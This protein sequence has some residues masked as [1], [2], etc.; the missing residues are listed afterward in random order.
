MLSQND[1]L[2][3]PKSRSA[4]LQRRIGASGKPE[5]QLYY[6][7]K[8]ISFDDPAHFGFGEALARQSRFSA[9][10]AVAWCS[11]EWPVVRDLLDQ[12]LENGVLRRG[13]ANATDEILF[14]RGDL[15]SPLP[16]AQLTTP[17]CWADGPDVMRDLTGTALEPGYLEL[18][19]PIFRV[20]HMFMDQDGRQIGEANVFPKALRLDVPTEWRTCAYPG[21]RYQT[22][23]PM[24]VTALRAMRAHWQQM[25]ALLLKVRAVYIARFPDA[26]DGW[27]VGHLERL[28]TAVL[29]LPSFMMLRHDAPLRNG[30]LHPVLSNLFRVTD[31]LRMTMH[32]MLFVPIA[33][34]MLKPSDTM[35]AA[36][37]FGYAERNY[38]FHSDHGVCAGPRF[39]IEEFLSVLIDGAEP[40]NGLPEHLDS[41]VEAAA[42][43]IEPALD[44]AMLGLQSYGVVFSL[45]PAMTRAYEQI[46]RILDGMP[47]SE[48]RAADSVRDRFRSH[49]HS[50]SSSYLANEDWRR[51]RE[52]VY[53]DMYAECYRAVH[54]KE[55]VELLSAQIR[56]SRLAEHG[57]ARLVLDL[58]IANRL[59]REPNDELVGKIGAAIMDFLGSAQ[60]ILKLAEDIQ[61]HTNQL[62]ARPQPQRPVTLADINLHNLLLGKDQR[63]LP[64]L[65][66][67]LSRLFGIE[68]RVDAN[69]IEIRERAA[70][71]APAPDRNS[72]EMVLAG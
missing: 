16:P 69:S 51:H 6:G 52:T 13:D 70:Q 40:K 49:V 39:M 45:W 37:V 54:G 31:G 65:P 10:D 46:H 28:S 17:R 23:R 56:A 50:V 43:L 41:E 61:Y 44:Y 7:D 26:A 30:A 32:Q 62:L 48:S 29:A 57:A 64:F 24:N 36:E 35:T 15:A 34:A 67:E 59:G 42:A 22:E 33:E 66:D 27:T 38:S 12:L 2:V 71:G 19:V 18:V 4:V 14:S 58:T 3:F 47:R 25:M 1:I 55:P 5:L 53:D 11:S 68:I 9:G 20:A 21:T 60:A 72:A 8:E 63:S